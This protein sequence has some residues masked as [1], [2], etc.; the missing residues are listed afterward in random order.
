M[1]AVGNDDL[2]KQALELY[3]REGID[4]S[5]VRVVDGVA[6]G[7]ALIFVGDD[8]ENMIGVAPGANHEAHPGRRRR[9]AA[10]SVSQ[11]D[12]LLV[13]LEIP[14]ETAIRALRR[15]FDAGMVTI[16]NPGTRAGACGIGGERAPFGRDRD[17]AQPRR[18]PGAGG[19]E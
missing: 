10:S 2:G 4:V 11:G 7:V 12:V 6:S 3:Q 18:G 19:D 17:H 14:V 5:H 9:F 15:G 1:T 16:L 8:G 13:S